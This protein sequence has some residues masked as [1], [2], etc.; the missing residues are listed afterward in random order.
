MWK[1][2]GI[3]SRRLPKA[4]WKSLLDETHKSRH[5]WQILAVWHAHALGT[6][7]RFHVCWVYWRHSC[8]FM[9]REFPW[10]IEFG[11]GAMTVLDSPDHP[12]FTAWAKQFVAILLSWL[13]I[14]CAREH[15]KNMLF[16]VTL[17]QRPHRTAV[18]RVSSFSCAPSTWIA[19]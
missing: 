3:N 13:D 19:I 17:T 15:L 18:R 8:L 5:S 14:C 4:I 11:C 9:D 10:K 7:M 12:C 1:N 16:C 2:E 6:F